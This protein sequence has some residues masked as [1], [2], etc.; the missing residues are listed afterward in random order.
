MP[1]AG[2]L[3]IPVPDYLFLAKC[4]I[5]LVITDAT[6]KIPKHNMVKYIM[7]G[8]PI[9]LITAKITLSKAVMSSKPTNA[10]STS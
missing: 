8:C 7:S 5:P 2:L 6:A 9:R 1:P 10:Y 3:N 4:S